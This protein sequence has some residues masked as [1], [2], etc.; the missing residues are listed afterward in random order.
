MDIASILGL[1]MIMGM[2][3]GAAFHQ[4]HGHLE[5]FYSTEGVLLVIMGAT[6]ATMVA[7]PMKN[8][9]QIF[10]VL[11]KCFFYKDVPLGAAILQLV[12][13]AGVAR[14]DGLLALEGRMAEVQEPFL[15]KGLRMVI[16]GQ[17]HHDVETT[18]RMELFALGERH[19]VGKKAFAMMGNFAPAYGLTATIIGQVVMFGSMGS[20]ISEIGKGLQVA[21]LGTL[22][23]TLFAN[24][25]CLP[26]TDK[27]GIRASQ[28]MQV[29]EL[30]LQGI[31]GIAAGDSPTALK[32]R[33][34][35]FLD[36]KA[37]SKMEEMK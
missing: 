28:E 30:Y 37:A 22:Y 14:K 27:L 36:G 6:C 33:L 21:L 11:K 26:F 20:D 7:M 13:F 16:D 9:L 24:V 29:K 34:V 15:A 18:L 4:T 31:M 10:G 17:D 23:G 19:A 8:F 1:L 3:G 35:S 25:V 12:E 32:Q 2:I 5:K